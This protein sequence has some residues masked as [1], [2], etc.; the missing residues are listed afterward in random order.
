ML[1]SVPRAQ[2]EKAIENTT[3]LVLQELRLHLAPS[4]LFLF[5]RRR[6]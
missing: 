6:L 3:A 2:L 1:D 4:K 5:L